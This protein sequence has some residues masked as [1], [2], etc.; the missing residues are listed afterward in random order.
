MSRRRR[1]ASGILWRRNSYPAPFSF[2]LLQFVYMTRID[3]QR[4]TLSAQRPI[5]TA[6]LCLIGVACIWWAI[7]Q[8]WLS[9]ADEAILLSIHQLSGKLIDPAMLGFTELGN[10]VGI[11]LTLGILM[12]I[13]W[14]GGFYAKAFTLL[15]SVC[16]AAAVNMVLKEWVMRARPTLW[17][18]SI[19]EHS[20]SCPSAHAMLTM[21]LAAS[22][23][24]LLWNTRWRRLSLLVGILYVFL[25]SLSR[26]YLGVH[27]PSDVLAG[28]LLGL[29]WALI[30][31][32]AMRK[33][34]SSAKGSSRGRSASG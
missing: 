11:I 31:I 5:S 3:W 18:P 1:R 23:V 25:V 34:H 8:G 6:V 14:F 2:S 28:W 26:L 7:S 9:V 19:M 12:A 29:A 32:E 30:V 16:G 17:T 27:Y 20:Y 24:S 10:E 21:A 15:I 4:L 13:W 33:Y 22:V